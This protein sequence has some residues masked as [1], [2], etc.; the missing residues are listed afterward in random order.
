MSAPAPRVG[1]VLPTRLGPRQRTHRELLAMA[2]AV[3]RDPGWDHLWVADGLIALPFYEATVLLAA[4]AARTS[5]VR[6]GINCQATLG[7]RHPAIAVQQWANLDALSDGRMTLVACPG[8]AT[9]AAVAQERAVFD[10]S[11]A[12]KLR[13]TEEAVGLLRSASV[14]GRAH[15]GAHEWE[16]RPPFTQTPLPIWFVGNPPPDAPAD[17]VERVLD[18]VA[19]LGDGWVTYNVSPALLR[20][21]VGALQALRVGQGSPSDATPQVCVYLNTCLHPDAAEAEA[22]AAEAWRHQS[23]RDLTVEGLREVGAIGDPAHVEGVVRAL[24][25]AGATH[26][27]LN[28]LSRDPARQIAL[29]AEH[30]LPRLGG[31][32]PGLR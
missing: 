10:V 9:G 24:A 19:R 12:T 1:V 27:A 31:D 6:L 29:M 30:L 3:D 11:Y 28:P 32:G 14:T 15:R 23:T 5:R 2:E 22:D 25:A 16:V 17:L 18:R 26:V 4:I 13:R 7:L 20:E 8:N 21:R